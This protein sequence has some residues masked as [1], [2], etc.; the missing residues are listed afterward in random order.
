MI[1]ILITY[2]LKGI[3]MTLVKER[4]QLGFVTLNGN[5]A[6]SGLVGLAYDH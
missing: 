4:R 3:Q 2:I 1:R 5:L 6:V